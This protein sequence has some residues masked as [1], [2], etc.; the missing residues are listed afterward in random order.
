MLRLSAW[1]WRF[2]ALAG[3]SGLLVFHS[4]LFVPL[5]WRD[6]SDTTPL[7]GLPD[8]EV[9]YVQPDASIVL[10]AFP[11]YPL[12]QDCTQTIPS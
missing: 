8:R 3:L 7:A 11:N 9:S 2:G 10:K 5:F 1:D 12:H 4:L 6:L